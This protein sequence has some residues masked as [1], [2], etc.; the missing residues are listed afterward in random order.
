MCEIVR[1][2]RRGDR[3]ARVSNDPRSAYDAPLREFQR[4]A[5]GSGNE[6]ADRHDAMGEVSEHRSS[7]GALNSL[8]SGNSSRVAASAQQDQDGADTTAHARF[9]D[10]LP[11]KGEGIREVMMVRGQARQTG[12]ISHGTS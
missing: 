7:I 8:S 11:P 5:A 4:R 1:G 3:K 2:L 9:Q 10:D 12:R 6:S